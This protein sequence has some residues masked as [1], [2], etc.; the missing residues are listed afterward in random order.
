MNYDIK[1]QLIVMGDSEVGKTSLLYRYQ[2]NKFT[3]NH[4]ATVGIDYFTKN[5]TIKDKKL[6][7]KIWDT[8]GQER[9]KSLTY[10]F[11]RNANGIILVYD[12]S[13]RDSFEHLMFWIA[14]INS[15]LGDSK[16]LKKIIIGNKIDLEKNVTK[17]EAEIFAKKNNCLYFETSAKDSIGISESM[18]T[19]IEAI[20]EDKNFLKENDINEY[21]KNLK[22]EENNKDQNKA[23]SANFNNK[24]KLNGKK[25]SN[26]EI[27]SLSLNSSKKCC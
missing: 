13:N 26:K 25:N 10:G 24:I 21:E 1:L 12:V 19:L 15:N 27:Y 3:K 2:D 18:K 9:Y 11:S 4:L 23:N 16:K 8:A 17:E 5:E 22:K 20:I 14:S 6:R 7:I